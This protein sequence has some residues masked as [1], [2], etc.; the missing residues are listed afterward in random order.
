M[1]KDAWQYLGRDARPGVRYRDGDPCARRDLWRQLLVLKEL[2][3]SRP[4]AL[5]DEEQLRFAFETMLDKCLGIVPERGDV[6][7]ASK[8][9]ETGLR[10][11]PSVRVLVR[12]RGTEGENALEFFVVE[13]VAHAQG[14]TLAVQAGEGDETVLVLDL[15]APP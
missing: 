14:G 12:F 3:K 6:Y 2:D 15:P 11:M 10:G 9:H 8:H 13:A 4:L 1:L 5:G 7:V